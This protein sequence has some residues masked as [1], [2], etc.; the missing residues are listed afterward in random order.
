MQLLVNAHYWR[1][2][3]FSNI[4]AREHIKVKSG[5]IVKSLNPREIVACFPTN[6]LKHFHGNSEKQ[7]LIFCRV[8][9]ITW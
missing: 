4:K 7:D 2:M 8:N 6:D 1:F 9:N 5:H 3:Y